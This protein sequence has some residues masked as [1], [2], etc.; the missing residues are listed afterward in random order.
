MFG[1]FDCNNFFVS[2]ERV[3]NPSLEG[4]PT[5]V[6]SGND[7]C[8]IARSNEAKELGIKMGDPL[9]KAQA[10]ITKHN[11]AIYSTNFN[12][13]GDMSR[14]VMS[15]LRSRTPAIEVYSI[16][17][18]FVDFSGINPSILI[19]YAKEVARYTHKSTGIPISLGLA[20][21]KT[22]A[23]IAS[24]LAKKEGKKGGNFYAFNSLEQ[25]EEQLKT[26]AI[27]DVW[28]IGRQ[29]I[30]LL[31]AHNIETAY[32]FTQCAPT[33]I[34]HQMSI[35]GLRIWQELRG[36]S[37]IEFCDAPTTRQT[38]SSSRSF[39]SDI[40]N[41]DI[42]KSALADY[43]T[44]AADRLRNQGS[45]CGQITVYLS[46]NRFKGST[47]ERTDSRMAFFEIP[48][49]STLEI[50]SSATAL[51]KEII[52]DGVEYKKAGIILSKIT[53]QSQPTQ[54]SL[55]DT[56]D[57]PKQSQL[58]QAV[59]KINA[60]YG[61]RSLTSARLNAQIKPTSSKNLSPNYT[62]KWSDIIKVKV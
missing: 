3:F 56:V 58:M 20:P 33:W 61:K 59:D 49:C 35:T 44:T 34:R 12:L 50:V 16:D 10:L 21:T 31:K 29:S 15:I 14:R 8:I 17:E 27:G 22:L 32:D 18:A 60:R 37:V 2:C 57:R 11:V 48:T 24:K 26:F 4:R 9:F 25:I 43:A 6:L 36:E 45:L 62:T 46:T 41:P 28:G 1:L 42:I 53:D 23:K 47:Q 38:I 5:V 13:Y 55:F 52:I 54:T 30:S 7:G 39:A 40:S 51:L 19:D